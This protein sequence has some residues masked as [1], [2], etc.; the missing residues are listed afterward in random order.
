MKELGV[1]GS[2][3]DPIWQAI[4]DRDWGLLNFLLGKAGVAG[5]D[6]D[7]ITG[8]AQALSQAKARQTEKVYGDR[9]SRDF[10]EHI[11]PHHACVTGATAAA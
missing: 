4:S 9:A 2:L 7:M 10:Q 3:C 11:W 1:A 8:A 5:V 6:K